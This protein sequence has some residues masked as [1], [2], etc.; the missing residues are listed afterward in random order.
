M[1]KPVIKTTKHYNQF[2]PTTIASGALSNF[3]ILEAVR[4]QDISTVIEVE[5]GAIIKAVYLEVWLT[6]DDTSQTS[7]QLV[8]QK[9]PS[10]VTPGVFAVMNTLGTYDNKKNVLYTTRGLA[11]ANNFGNPVPIVRGWFKIPK[12]KQRMG[13]GDKMSLA[14]SAI[15]NGITWCGFMTYKEYT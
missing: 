12:G 15:A 13:L 6:S 10:G 14:I 9:L 2:S 7:F 1:V 8:L 3:D 5:E 4:V 11:P